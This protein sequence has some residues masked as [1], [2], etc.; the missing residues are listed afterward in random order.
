[1]QGRPIPG[2]QIRLASENDTELPWDGNTIGELQVRSPW[3]ASSYYKNEPTPEHFTADRW[4]RTG[5]LATINAEGYIQIV[6]RAKALIRSGGESISTVALETVLLK[7]PQVIEVAVIGVPDKK[8]GERPIA[9]V[10][11]SSQEDED[12]S[13][14]LK[15]HI[16]TELPKFWIPDKFVVVNNI[17]KTTVG[18]SD[19]RAIFQMFTPE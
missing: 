1:M 13:D 10:V 3:T 8:W 11:L 9:V 4:L 2:V 17:P 7:H 19:K 15:Q 16:A 5:D 12:I 14:I 18:K 6:D